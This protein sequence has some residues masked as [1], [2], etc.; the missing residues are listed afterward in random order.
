MVATT[1]LHPGKMKRKATG[2]ADHEQHDDRKGEVGRF[3]LVFVAHAQ[4]IGLAA[5]GAGRAGAADPSA[6]RA[7]LPLLV[8][9]LEPNSGRELTLQVLDKTA[10][11]P[12]RGAVVWVRSAR[13][14]ALIPG[15]GRPTTKGGTS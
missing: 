9:E 12:L 2:W 7:E 14:A 4:G 11:S 3:G 15:R 1:V 13:A 8:Q 6:A 10:T 5:R